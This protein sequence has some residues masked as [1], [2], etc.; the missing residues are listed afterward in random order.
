MLKIS[1]YLVTYFAV[2]PD[3]FWEFWY[4][5]FDSNKFELLIRKSSFIKR[6]KPVL[7]RTTKTFSLDLL[8]LVLVFTFYDQFSIFNRKIKNIYELI[9][10]IILFGN[11]F[12][13]KQWKL[14]CLKKH[15][16]LKEMFFALHAFMCR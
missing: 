12:V 1:Q 15:G 9:R 16:L 4:V 7:N 6:D 13:V 11:T 3:N 2:T 8:D 5:A 10:Q 14:N